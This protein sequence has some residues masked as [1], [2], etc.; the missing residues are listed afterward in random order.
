MDWIKFRVKVRYFCE[1]I[2]FH[3]QHVFILQ[4]RAYAGNVSAHNVRAYEGKPL[5]MCRMVP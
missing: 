3:R 1:Q 4:L 5:R 2:Y